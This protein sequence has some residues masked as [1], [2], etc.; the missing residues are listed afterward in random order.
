MHFWQEYYRYYAALSVHHIMVFV[1]L[2]CLVT[3]DVNLHLLV[4]VVSAKFLHS[5]VTIF[6]L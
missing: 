1:T 5:T 3:G 4:K 6:P 2:I